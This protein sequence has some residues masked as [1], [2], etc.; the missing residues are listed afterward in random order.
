MAREH[1]P[2]VTVITPAYNRADYLEEVILSVLGQ[3]YPD[4]EYIVLDDGS[5]DGT[6]D[7][8]RKFEGRIEPVFQSNMGETRTVNKGFSMA[9]GE[10]IGVVNSDDPLEAGAIRKIAGRLASAQDVLV[11]YPDWNMIDAR[12][13]IIRT[14]RTHEYNYLDMLRWHHC[15]PGPGAF[16]RREIV[17]RLGGRDPQF[18]YVADFDF[19]LRAGLHGPFERFPEPLATFR[20]HPDSASESAKGLVM[21]EEHIRL[22]KKMYALP[23]LPDAVR[24]VRREALSSAY[25]VAGV[26]CGSEP[27]REKRRL[28]L[29][30]LGYCPWKYLGEYADR[31]SHILPTVLG[32]AYGYPREAWKRLSGKNRG[33]EGS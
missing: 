18:R 20:V 29:K 10:I 33:G 6:A 19:W 11:V 31:R 25:F 30:A 5:T 16:F 1:L 23:E 13:R 21:A 17:D 4:L 8:M 27:N 7:V 24:R 26:V 3:D 9:R 2:P 12:G 28:F 14:V 22:V 32:K 15:I